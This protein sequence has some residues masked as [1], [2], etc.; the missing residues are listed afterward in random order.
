LP[1]TGIG[2]HADAAS[3]GPAVATVSLLS[4]TIMRMRPRF[5]AAEHFAIALQPGD[6]AVMTGPARSAWTNEIR[7]EDV[8]SRRLSVAFRTVP[9]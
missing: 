3:F 7:G 6:C 1:G 4:P 2:E 9:R 8:R 5:R